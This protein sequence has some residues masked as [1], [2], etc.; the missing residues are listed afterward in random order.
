MEEDGLKFRE[1]AQKFY[2]SKSTIT[3]LMNYKSVISSVGHFLNACFILKAN[4]TDQI[5]KDGDVLFQPSAP[6]LPR[7]DQC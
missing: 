4:D 7:D 1:D 2:I 5:Q 3:F 6:S